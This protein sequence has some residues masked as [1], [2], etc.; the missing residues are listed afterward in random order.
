M[1]VGAIIA[2]VIIVIAIAAAVFFVA[3]RKQSAPSLRR[4]FGPE[5]DR[6]AKEAG[7]RQA[8]AELADRQQRVDKLNIHPLTAEQYARHEGE[9]TAAQEWFVES[10]TQAV[11]SAATLITAV[12]ADRG[13]P[14]D[15]RDQL[16]ADL[17]V[18]HARQLG[19]FRRA[20]RTTAG[21]NSQATEDL[22]QELLDC[23]ALFSELLGTPDGTADR[24]AVPAS[25]TRTD[26]PAADAPAGSARGEQLK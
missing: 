16:L 13:Y 3:K 21:D 19:G 1:P 5:Y 11:Q 23:R 17:S 7:S 10:P 15:D 4:Q 22:R 6:L 18:H 2:V 26:V 24:R 12:A 14:V 8:E 20:S 25:A 9:W